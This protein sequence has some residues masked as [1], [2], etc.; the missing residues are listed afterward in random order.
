[1]ELLE[2]VVESGGG[3]GEEEGRRRGSKWDREVGSL[4]S[5]L[6]REMEKEE[7]VGV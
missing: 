4:W 7:R 3:R 6:R 1:M 5:E 2:L